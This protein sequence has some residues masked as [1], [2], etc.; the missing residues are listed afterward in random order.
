[1]MHLGK[2]FS[3]ALHT[4][5][6]SSV[7]LSFCYHNK[8]NILRCYRNDNAKQ[9]K[10][11]HNA[12]ITGVSCVYNGHWRIN[13][14]ICKH[15]VA[16]IT[17]Q[18]QYHPFEYCFGNEFGV[19]SVSFVDEICLLFLGGRQVEHYRKS[20]QSVVLSEYERFVFHVYDVFHFGD[21]L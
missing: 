12:Y 5:R 3:I 21:R 11:T 18:P 6:I 13:I 10:Y 20:A 17:H 2:C 16:A 19:K 4:F 1:M 14:Y 7:Y 9:A 8:P 15:E